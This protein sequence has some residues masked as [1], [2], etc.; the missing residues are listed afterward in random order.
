VMTLIMLDIADID[1]MNEIRLLPCKLWV[2]C[3]IV[4]ESQIQ[5]TSSSDGSRNPTNRES[6][7][8]LGR[9]L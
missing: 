5:T 2:L 3:W 7:G 1:N 6:C 4:L 8:N 9:S